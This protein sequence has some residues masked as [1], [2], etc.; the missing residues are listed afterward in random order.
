[1]KIISLTLIGYRNFKLRQIHHFQYRPTLK[2]QLILGTNGSG[3]SCL[4]RELSPLP[5]H[6][7]D[8]EKEGRKEIEISHNGKHYLLQSLFG[9]E[10][11]RYPFIVDGEN[12]NPGFTVTV[13][14]E[15]VKEHFN[16]TPEVHS[17]LIGSIRF[18]TMSINDRRSWFMKISDTDYTYALKYY[19]KLK[20]KVR[21]LQGALKLNQTRLTQETNK[22]LTEKDEEILRLKIQELNQI[23]N[24]LIDHRKPRLSNPENAQQTLM[25]IESTLK[26]DISRLETIL[27]TVSQSGIGKSI[28]TLEQDSIALQATLQSHQNEI[29]K[30]CESIEKVQKEY[31]AAL[32]SSQH[33][34]EEVQ[35]TLREFE[36]NKLEL[37]SQIRLPLVFDNVDSVISSL[38]A[39][40]P[41]LEDILSQ[42]SQCSKLDY[43]R[44]SYQQLLDISP[45]LNQAY[46][47]L[48]DVESKLFIQKQHL[49]SHRAKGLTECPQCKHEWYPNYDELKYKQVCKEHEH[50]LLALTKIEKE[51]QENK[52][53]IEEHQHFFN[54]LDRYNQNTRHFESL[55]PLW[56]Y[57]KASGKLLEEPDSLLNLIQT[58]TL[59]LQYHKRCALLDERI[60]E[61]Q[62]LQS[63]MENTKEV[64]V[65]KLKQLMINEHDRLH[66]LQD[67]VRL[68]KLLLETTKSQIHTLNL[69]NQLEAKITTS[70]RERELHYA[71]VIEDQCVAA[72]D[73]IIRNVKLN[74][75]QY[76]RTLSQID[77]QK[78]IVVSLSKQIKEIEYELD[79]LKLAQKALSPTE[80]LIAKG[81]TGF[82][83]H[84]VRE[85]NQFIEGIWLYPLEILPIEMEDDSL[86]LDY[87]FGV[88]VNNDPRVVPDISKASRGMQEV[89]NL[90]FVAVSMKYLGLSNTP[91]FLD[92]FA[93]SLDVAH[94]QSAYKAIDH[95]IESTDYSQVFL[96]S[97]YQDGYSSLNSS[98]VL[99]LCDSNIELPKGMAYN[100]HVQ[101][102]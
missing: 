24:T 78:A 102:H 30:I 25:A 90:A 92:E 15:L 95:L 43:N 2:T 99:V 10:G 19:Q 63:L 28:E 60:K 81:M 3:K 73:E 12:L 74:L 72:L 34:L 27:N 23:L 14:K 98:E 94:R 57:I 26:Q 62:K 85:V 67:E 22:C 41:S 66:F 96:V 56:A 47:K 93:A 40:K 33:S 8:F 46:L 75:S 29:V 32:S 36:E 1:M 77:I 9:Q 17:L 37:Q 38:E 82:I 76:E 16:Y 55:H 44:I 97:H 20:E 71:R 68:K 89:I 88:R 31:D 4:L 79:L 35:R 5:A 69:I 65:S 13:Y 100:H 49:E 51:I 52:K 101:F 61:H 59:D 83:N 58:L 21:D 45:H 6:H 7:S 84:F 86:D 11:N 39:V 87:R 64:D 48:K 50:L 70:F 91:I 42:L 80:G 53:S 54:L 18:P